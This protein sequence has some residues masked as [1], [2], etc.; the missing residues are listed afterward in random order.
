VGGGRQGAWLNVAGDRDTGCQKPKLIISIN[1]KPETKRH[2]GNQFSR[3]AV[4]CLQL[5][6]WK[7]N[8]N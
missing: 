6:N 7:F 1:F 3:F 2:K 8:G 5:P 4:D